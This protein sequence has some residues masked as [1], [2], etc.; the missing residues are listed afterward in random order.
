MCLR[1]TLSLRAAA[2]AIASAAAW[3]GH[4]LG[5]RRSESAGPARL[6][7]SSSAACVLAALLF[8]LALGAPAH[9]QRR[10]LDAMVVWTH[11]DL[12]YMASGD[13]GVFSPGMT[14]SIR[15]GSRELATGRIER[16]YEPRL[17]VVRTLSGSLANEDRLHELS[18]QGESAMDL[19]LTRLRVGL[20]ARS[21]RNLLFDCVDPGVTTTFAREHFLVDTLT[22]GALRMR[23]QLESPGT[24]VAPDTLELTFFA[25]ATDAEIALERGDL[26]VAL[27]WPGELSARTRGSEHVFA[28]RRSRG[29]L[30]AVIV[31][32]DTAWADVS[33]LGVLDRQLF[34]GDLAD[35][36]GFMPPDQGTDE[37]LVKPARFRADARLP[38]AR[39]FER[40]L[41]RLPLGPA[42]HVAELRYLDEPVPPLAHGTTPDWMRRRVQPLYAMEC[43][44]VSSA[45]AHALVAA[46]GANAFAD[47]L[48]CGG[49]P[50]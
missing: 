3:G 47:L 12:I 10:D 16:M 41:A 29:L 5:S 45:R 46:L 19:R 50:R 40:V 9:A 28:A 27:F 31:G 7:R 23:R 11:A 21:R 20:P 26:D 43:R 6:S 35:W 48:V 34:A 44:V 15:R 42:S 49:G 38:G 8:L 36:N 25:E 37:T 33:R 17:V 24:P 1:H 39:A 4:S 13:S 2:H 14:L 30:A 18:I 32:R 22:N